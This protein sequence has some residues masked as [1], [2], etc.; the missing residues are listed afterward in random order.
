MDKDILVLKDGT[1][2]ELEAGANL[3]N[4]QVRSANK[5]G[6]VN[7][8]DKLTAENLSSVQIKNGSGLTVGK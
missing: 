3:F 2:V 1:A 5:V 4:M 7:V 6:M 8:W